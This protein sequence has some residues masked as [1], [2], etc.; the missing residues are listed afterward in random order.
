MDK[1]V[2]KDAKQEKNAKIANNQNEITKKGFKVD[3]TA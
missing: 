3:T 1:T 2:E